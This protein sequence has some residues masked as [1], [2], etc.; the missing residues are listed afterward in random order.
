MRK[1]R[2]LYSIILS[3]VKNNLK[4]A[5]VLDVGCGAGRLAIMCAKFAKQVDAFDF[6]HGAISIAQKIAE[7]T[8]TKNI[9]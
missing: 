9:E 7:L 5:E 3:Q 2:V 1:H 4:N 8:Q 6:S